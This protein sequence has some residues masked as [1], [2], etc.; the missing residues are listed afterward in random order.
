LNFVKNVYIVHRAGKHFDWWKYSEMKSVKNELF[1]R[2]ELA[3][4]LYLESNNLEDTPKNNRDFK[5]AVSESLIDKNQKLSKEQREKNFQ[6]YLKEQKTE[7]KTEEEIKRFQFEWQIKE[8]G[9][10]MT[11]ERFK[12]MSEIAEI[13]TVSPKV[14]ILR[15]CAGCGKEEISYKATKIQPPPVP[16]IFKRCGACQVEWYCGRECQVKHWPQHKLVCKSKK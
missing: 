8:T 9:V 7:P 1:D 3:Y 10:D 14:Q 5:L 13:A 15:N 2:L 6:K 16:L 4:K 12:E 11:W